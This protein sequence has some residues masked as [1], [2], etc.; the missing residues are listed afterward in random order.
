MRKILAKFFIIE[1]LSVF[2]IHSCAPSVSGYINPEFSN[3]DLFRIAI[4]P[5]TDTGRIIFD[6]GNS[7]INNTIIDQFTIELMKTGKFHIFERSQ[8]NHIINEQKF[9]L[10]DITE[11]QR[12]QIGE[13]A[14]IDALFLLSIS[15]YRGAA[16]TTDISLNAKLVDIKTG[17]II[18]AGNA[19]SDHA[20]VLIGTVGE[21]IDVVINSIMR[22]IRYNF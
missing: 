3:I 16:G 15:T 6:I 22:D 18:Y 19:K 11:T 14:N 4:L 20:I 1:L 10:S 9:S 17:S 21:T 7:G 5:V 13:L 8:I 2:I 12:K